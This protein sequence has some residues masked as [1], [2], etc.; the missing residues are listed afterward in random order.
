[1]RVEKE[2]LLCIINDLIAD[3][4][5]NTDE[6]SKENIDIDIEALCTALGI[7]EKELEAYREEYM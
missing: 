6:N 5:F 2:A 3:N 7:T 1:M 4:G